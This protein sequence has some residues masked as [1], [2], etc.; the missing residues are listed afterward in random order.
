MVTIEQVEKLRQYA[1][2]SYEEA[3]VA[4]EK[5]NGDILEALIQLEQQGKAKSPEG[6]GRFV[7]KTEFFGEEEKTGA[8][9]KGQ[10]DGS[11]QK[12]SS[13]GDSV[14]RFFSWLGK[15]IQKGN[16]NVLQVRRHNEDIIN[17]PLTILVLLLLFGFWAIIPI[18]I[19]G[20]F[21]SFTYSF[22]GPDIGNE[23]VNK[24]MDDVAKAAEDIKNDIKND[25]G[26]DN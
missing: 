14:K 2:I 17:L 7:S 22:E 26:K 5:T 9:S 16:V 12:G 24:V 15:I 20:L 13:F 10:S 8:K 25:Q 19:I 6:G 21:F 3:K 4:L 11:G 1:E 18:M 23:K